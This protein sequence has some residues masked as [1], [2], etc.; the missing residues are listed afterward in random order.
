L[1][2]AFRSPPT[3][4]LRRWYAVLSGIAWWL[5]HLVIEA[6]LVRISCTHPGWRIVMHAVTIVT[7]LGTIVA[8]VWSAQ[9][10]REHKGVDDEGS[11]LPNRER[12]LGL[13][14]VAIGAISLLLILWEG[15]YVLALS[16]C[17]SFGG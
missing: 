3:H 8:I 16:S 12:F 1:I 9:M 11:G 17:A 5:A 15:F 14:G 4:G 10:A 2:A 7:A 6:S 13:F